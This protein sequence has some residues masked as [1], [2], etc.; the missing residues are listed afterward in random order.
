[1]GFVYLIRNT[2]NGKCY[3]GQTRRQDVQERWKEHKRRAGHA[4]GAAFD[5]HGKDKFE[6]SVICEVPDEDL[7]DREVSEI[8]ERET[9]AP[10]GYNLQPGGEYR[11][12][13]EETKRKIGAN[14]ALKLKGK[15]MPE[16]TKE[17]LRKANTDRHTPRTEEMKERDREIKRSAMK[18][19]DQ[20]TLDGVFVKAWESVRA[21]GVNGVRQCCNGW[22]RSSGGF[23]WK[24]HNPPARLPPRPVESAEA[25]TRRNEL[26]RTKRAAA[27][28]QRLAPEVP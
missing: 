23:T 15:K 1:M 22:M 11:D 13:N 25:K 19:V 28:V 26:R 10:N 24:W 2:V 3:V 16:T 7:N 8:A 12:M 27:R 14:S 5:F 18:P 20:Y 9:L 21:T 17:A 6:F 4:L